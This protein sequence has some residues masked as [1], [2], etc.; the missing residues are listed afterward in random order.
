MP[1]R[2]APARPR[3]PSPPCA[4]PCWACCA[5]TAT[6]TSP[7][8][9]AISPGR[10]APPSV[11]SAC[12]LHNEKTLPFLTSTLTSTRTLTAILCP[13]CLSSSLLHFFWSPMFM[14]SCVHVLRRS[15]SHLSRVDPPC[16][17]AVGRGPR[18]L[19][20]ACLESRGSR[21]R[22]SC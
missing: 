19:P 3:R 2:S 12:I 10:P 13:L 6:P 5:S 4:M 15:R 20:S 18:L 7:R 1:V 11:F 14:C 17:P 9:C 8:L 22:A 21:C 16:H